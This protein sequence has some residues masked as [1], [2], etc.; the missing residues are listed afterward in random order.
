MLGMLDQL[1]AKRVPLNV[2][3]HAN[4]IGFG[5]YRQGDEPTLIQGTRPARAMSRVPS[6]GMCARDPVHQSRKIC[7]TV[8]DNDEVPVIRHQAVR[9]YFHGRFREALPNDPE[10]GDVVGGTVKDRRAAHRAI[11]HV[12]HGSL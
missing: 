8:A 5:L 12:E 3:A 6:L 7:H 1:G 10:K 11:D 9:N 4:Q 2:P